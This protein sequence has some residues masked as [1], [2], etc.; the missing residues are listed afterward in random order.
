MLKDTSSNCNGISFGG[1][2]LK[3]Y[4]HVGFSFPLVDE[5]NAGEDYCALLCLRA[6]GVY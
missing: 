6:L 3:F 5:A 4:V 2:F 1:A